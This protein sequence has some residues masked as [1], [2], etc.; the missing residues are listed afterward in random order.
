MMTSEGRRALDEL[1]QADEDPRQLSLPWGGRSPRCLT[2]A[3]ARFSLPARAATL[4]E[5]FDEDIIDEQHRRFL[6]P[7]GGE[8]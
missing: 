8:E 6:E 2:K 5:F 1:R 7:Y 3:Y 4:D